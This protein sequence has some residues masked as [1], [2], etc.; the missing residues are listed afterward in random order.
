MVNFF[1]LIQ[2]VFK[3]IELYCRSEAGFSGIKN[4]YTRSVTKDDVQQSFFLAETLKYLYLLFSP[5]DVMPLDKWVFNT[6]AHPLPVRVKD[7]DH[8]PRPVTSLDQQSR[9]KKLEHQV[10]RSAG[11]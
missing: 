7:E 2:S 6:E 8:T 11:K 1:L 3:A 4:V 10:S 5:D 9:Y